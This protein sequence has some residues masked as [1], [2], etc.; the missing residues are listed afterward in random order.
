MPVYRIRRTAETYGQAVGILILDSRTP[1]VPGDAGNAST[2]GYPVMYKTVPGLTTMKCLCGAPEFEDKIAEAAQ[3][4]EREGVRAISSNCGF[5]IQFQEVVRNA[6]KVPV[7][8]SSLLQLPIIARSM[9]P[10]RP[11][12]IVT[13]D[14][15]NLSVEFLERTGVMTKNRVFITGLQDEREFGTAVFG[16]YGEKGNLDLDLVEEE[17]V[18]AAKQMVDEHPKMG[19]ILLECAMLPPYSKAVQEATGLPVYDFVTLIDYVQ[20]GSHKKAYSDR[21]SSAA[22]R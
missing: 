12:G 13:A 17:T 1:Y 5:M 14:S 19:A 20:S 7:C 8:M 22:V 21:I 18:R 4:L 16:R 15:S 11:I 10:S 3:E 6:V 9:E 2:Y